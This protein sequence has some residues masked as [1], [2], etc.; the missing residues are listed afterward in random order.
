[1]TL[2]VKTLLL[3]ILSCLILFAGKWSARVYR[4][5]NSSEHFLW[6]PFCS[7]IQ[8]GIFAKGL[9]LKR[10]K[11]SRFMAAPFM[12]ERGKEHLR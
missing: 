12:E 4:V 5:D 2:N 11:R 10:A 3:W 8:K 9:L 6:C 7:D 1:M